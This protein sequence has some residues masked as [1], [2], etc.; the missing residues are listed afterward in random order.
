MADADLVLVTGA[1]GFIGSHLCDALL[2][3]GYR[4]RAA[5]SLAGGNAANLAAARA[6]QGFEFAQA[7]L[8]D[9]ASCRRV[10]AGVRHVLH[11]AALASV[12]V[13]ISDPLRCHRDTLDTTANLLAAAREAGAARFVLASTAAVYG[14]TPAAPVAESMPFDPQSPYAA[15]KAAGE[16]YVQAFARMGLDGVSLRYFNAYGPR[17]D[18]RSAYSGVISIMADRLRRNEPVT[19]YGD[20]G[21]TR[22][23]VHVSDIVAADLLALA[24]RQP[25]AGAALNIGSGRAVTIREVA[26][27]IGRLLGRT[28]EIRLQPERPGDI[29]HSCADVS[30]A[31]RV[32]GF[33]ARVG[34]ADGLRDLLGQA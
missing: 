22:D 16:L 20:G 25:L 1:A 14:R 32:L 18:P 8:A 26:E 10:C 11:H 13:S 17:Q 12:P 24:A 27:L 28:P 21:A 23:F 15:S 2:D 34:L 5:D 6:K 33:E 4:V 19:I 7:D 31:R 3:A 30:A 29:R 9:G